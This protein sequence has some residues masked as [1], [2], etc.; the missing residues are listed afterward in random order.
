MSKNISESVYQSSPL[1]PFA[2]LF[3]AGSY[4]DSGIADTTLLPFCNSDDDDV[5]SVPQFA[6]CS[7]GPELDGSFFG[8]RART[9]AQGLLHIDVV[10]PA[11]VFPAGSMNPANLAETAGSMQPHG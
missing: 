2:N 7:D 9:C 1:V 3:T 6:R 4:S 5:W 11:T 10:Q 8:R